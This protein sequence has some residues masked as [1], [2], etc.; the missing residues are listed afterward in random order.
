LHEL[1]HDLGCEYIVCDSPA[2]IEKGAFMALYFADQAIVVTNPE[3][4]SVRDS[5]RILGMLAS[6]TQRAIDGKEGIREHLLITRYDAAR[7]ASGQMLSIDDIQEILRI[8]LIGV[9]PES[10]DVLDASNQG[11]PAIHMNASAVAEA[12]KDVTRRFLGE[13]R[14]MR[15]TQAARPSFFQRLFARA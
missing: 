1:Q 9:I 14:E 8:P 10:A 12:Y 3:V 11:V 13:S 15:F 4:S 6:K 5:D 2:G 7:V